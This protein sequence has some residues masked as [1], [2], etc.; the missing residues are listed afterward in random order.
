MS[1]S[2]D[3]RPAGADQNRKCGNNQ[4]ATVTGVRKGASL[5]VSN[6]VAI[7]QYERSERNA[8]AR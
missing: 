4:K 3:W 6:L 5:V 1:W 2:S 7:P 8:A